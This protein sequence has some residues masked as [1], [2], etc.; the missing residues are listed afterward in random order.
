MDT[1]GSRP[2]PADQVMSWRSTLALPKELLLTPCQVIYGF[3]GSEYYARYFHAPS[4]AL[5]V[6]QL[7]LNLVYVIPRLISQPMGS[8]NRIRPFETQIGTL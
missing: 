8:H 7:I 2:Q 5:H 6:Y 1:V 3:L 4:L